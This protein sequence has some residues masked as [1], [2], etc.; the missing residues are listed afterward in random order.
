MTG[1]PA[2]EQFLRTDPHDVGCEQAM[3]VLE[4]YVGLILND[5]L[6][7]AGRGPTSPWH[8]T[9]APEIDAFC[10]TRISIAAAVSRKRTMPSW[11]APATKHA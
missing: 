6:V 1:W 7:V 4:I 5:E 8:P 11:S 3:A 10:L 9:S 2:L